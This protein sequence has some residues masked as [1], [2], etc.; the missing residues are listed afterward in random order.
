MTQSVEKIATPGHGEP[1]H[2][3]PRL[4]GI[5]L[6][7]DRQL[8]RGGHQARAP[9]LPGHVSRVECH[10]CS[11]VSRVSRVP[12]PDHGWAAV[13]LDLAAGAHRHLREAD[14]V[15]RPGGRRRHG[16]QGGPALTQLPSL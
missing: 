9:P 14:P 12:L 6:L 3:S 8:R 4:H 13:P 7:P 16:H 10:V 5:L 15:P 2:G 11:I 1:L